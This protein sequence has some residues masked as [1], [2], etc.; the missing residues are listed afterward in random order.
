MSRH[1]LAVSTRGCS[2]PWQPTAEAPAGDTRKCF[3][4]CSCRAV[5]AYTQHAYCQYE[6]RLSQGKLGLTAVTNA[7]Y[8]ACAFS[9]KVEW[10]IDKVTG[11]LASASHVA[12]KETS[13]FW[14]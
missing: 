6:H 8:G 2:R 3:G 12:L 9:S 14:L 10:L 7:P 5:Y 13:R 1:P 4:R 11:L